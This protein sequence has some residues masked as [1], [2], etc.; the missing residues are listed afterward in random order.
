MYEG[1][2]SAG[3]QSQ[4]A[5]EMQAHSTASSF[6]AWT[7]QVRDA[8]CPESIMHVSILATGPALAMALPATRF[9]CF[10]TSPRENSAADT[11]AE[12]LPWTQR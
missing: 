10:Y 3:R 5:L 9:P 1:F 4:V 11:E 6:C 12:L 8:L 7:M 2:I